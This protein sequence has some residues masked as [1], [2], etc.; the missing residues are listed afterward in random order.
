[1]VEISL[2]INGEIITSEVPD[3]ITLLDFLKRHNVNSV[4][5][6]CYHGDCG[7]CTVLID[8]HVAKSCLVLTAE[9][10]ECSIITVEGLKENRIVSLL[11]KYFEKHGAVQ[12]GYCTP[13]FIV[14]AFQLLQLKQESKKELSRH[15]VTD[16]INGVLCRCTGYQ[17]IIDGII[18]A[19]KE[20]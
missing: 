13:A 16:A 9:V 15:E 3:N 18:E 4:K 12:C 17:Q 10:N 5:A 20:I 2:K 7:I 14:V 6:A 11:K 19:S 1:M 8:N